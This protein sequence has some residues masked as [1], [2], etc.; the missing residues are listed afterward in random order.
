MKYDPPKAVW[1]TSGGSG[2]PDLVFP[3]QSDGEVHILHQMLRSVVHQLSTGYIVGHIAELNHVQPTFTG[4]VHSGFT[5]TLSTMRF[6]DVVQYAITKKSK[7]DKSFTY[8]PWLG[9][10]QL[11]SE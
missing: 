4:G 11:P 3:S 8:K 9:S 2:K 1:T 10:V 5:Y 6:E 7:L